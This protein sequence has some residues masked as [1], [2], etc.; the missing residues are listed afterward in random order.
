[1]LKKY[2]ILIFILLQ[3]QVLV[4]MTRAAG[5]KLLPVQNIMSVQRFL[6]SYE[7]I[8]K[9][10]TLINT[11]RLLQKRV[12]EFE[13]IRKQED[14]K[15]IQAMLYSTATFGMSGTLLLFGLAIS[16][17]GIPN[18][19]VLGMP[20]AAAGIWGVGQTYYFLFVF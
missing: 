7:K 13:K 8:N 3:F 1:M 10:T 18:S 15:Q 6:S 4:P 14:R 2:L 16:T 17:N 5:R 19:V 11:S 9:E 12:N 20:F